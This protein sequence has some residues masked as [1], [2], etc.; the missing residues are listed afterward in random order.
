MD[1]L[2]R[3]GPGKGPRLLVI[4]CGHA[5]KRS[6]RESSGQEES[7]AGM[8]GVPVENAAGK[9][10]IDSSISVCTVAALCRVDAS[11]LPFAHMVLTGMRQQ[12][13]LVWDQ[14]LT[15]VVGTSTGSSDGIIPVLLL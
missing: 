15:V 12:N 2:R 11:I 3:E 9:E 14:R 5:V 8:R 1:C 10:T 6:F 7:A 4:C 13:D